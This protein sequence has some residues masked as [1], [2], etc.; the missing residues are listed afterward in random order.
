MKVLL[1]ALAFLTPPTKTHF[2]LDGGGG[3]DL[4]SFISDAPV[5]QFVGRTSAVTG[6]I[7]ID[8]ADVTT[9]SVDFTVDLSTLSTGIDGRDKHMKSAEYLSTDK[10]PKAT[11]KSKS[12]KLVEGGKTLAPNQVIAVEIAGDLTIR[13]ITKPLTT[14]A[15]V[16][17]IKGDGWS[18]KMLGPGDILSV[19]AQFPIK[20]TDFG[21]KVPQYIV[22]KVANEVQIN[23]KVN[24]R[25]QK[26]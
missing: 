6:A 20:M 1:L 24:A 26:M 19:S 25:T 9:G 22:L 8:L 3:K 21:M 15:L 23:V 17:Y 18:A 4:V 14:K 10:F 12:V 11:F 5:E 2:L 7:D 13:G 16:R